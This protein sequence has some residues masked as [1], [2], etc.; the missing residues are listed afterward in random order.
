MKTI[1]VS[2]ND[3]DGYL[4]YADHFYIGQLSLD[5]DVFST[6]PLSVLGGASALDFD[7]T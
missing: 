4:L 6:L 7:Y 2:G 5:G 1:L 3:T